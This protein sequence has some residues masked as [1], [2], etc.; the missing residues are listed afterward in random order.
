[1]SNTDNIDRSYI[2]KG[3]VITGNVESDGDLT[4][5]GEVIG[6]VSISG[7]LELNGSIRG[8]KLKVGRVELTEGVIESDIECDDY[9]RVG[10][11]VTI[12]GNIKAKNADVDGAVSGN[13][14]VQNKVIVGSTAVVKGNLMADELG[15][16]LGARCDVDLTKSYKNGTASDFFN[17]YMSER[18]IPNK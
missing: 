9:I 13:L 18:G 4:V 15:I 17:Q 11:N 12:L 2:P 5:A 16:N 3:M 10:E 6:N 7:T 8:N 14:D 1:M